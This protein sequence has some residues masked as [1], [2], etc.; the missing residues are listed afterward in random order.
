MWLRRHVAV[1]LGL[2]ALDF[3]SAAHRVDH[4]LKLD[5]QPVAG[6]LD[7]AAV[8]LGD[9]GGAQ[10]APDGSQRRES[11]LLVLAHQPRIAGNVDRQDRRQPPLDPPLAHMAGPVSSRG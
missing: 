7:D 11:A 2:A 3:D 10:F 6:G 4:V 8:M 1:A 9:L 5:E